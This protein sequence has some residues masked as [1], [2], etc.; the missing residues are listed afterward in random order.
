ML[1][2]FEQVEADKGYKSMCPQ[3]VKTHEFGQTANEV[4]MRE[5][6][7]AH[8]EHVNGRFK[9]WN[10]LNS[11]FRHNKDRMYKH[12]LVFT[13]VVVI[14]QISFSHGEPLKPVIYVDNRKRKRPRT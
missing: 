2:P 6:V 11:K 7:L 14:T 9:N 5:E 10:A 3:Y 12:G 1:D 13:A 8:H 4:F